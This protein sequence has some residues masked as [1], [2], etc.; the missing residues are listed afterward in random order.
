MK[1]IAVLL[2]VLMCVGSI[3]SSGNTESNTEGG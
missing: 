1:R 2:V 3:F